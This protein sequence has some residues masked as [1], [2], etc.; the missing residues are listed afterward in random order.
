MRSPFL[1]ILLLIGAIAVKAQNTKASSKQSKKT[2]KIVFQL[3][4]GDPEVHKG[5]MRQLG[6]ILEEAHKTKIEIVCHGPGMDMLVREKTAVHEKIQDFTKK[7]VVF[8]ACENTMK[9]K[10]IEREAVV[11]EAGYVKAGIIYIVER[12]DQGWSYIKAGF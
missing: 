5:L 7:G 11:A 4:N 12:Q 9:Q 6:H 10:N 8:F 3:S 1:I 2:H